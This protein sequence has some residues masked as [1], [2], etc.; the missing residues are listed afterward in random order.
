VLAVMIV[1]ILVLIINSLLIQNN[2]VQFLIML[3]LS[4]LL[5]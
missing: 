2:L 1:D 4:N 5:I 3:L